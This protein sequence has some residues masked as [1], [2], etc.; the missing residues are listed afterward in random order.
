MTA[1][2]EWR[3]EWH[4]D[5]VVTLARCHRL[6]LLSLYAQIRRGDRPARRLYLPLGR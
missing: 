3:R 6:Y 1:S 2:R 4:D 5:V